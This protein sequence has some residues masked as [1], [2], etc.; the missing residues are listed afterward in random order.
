M[1]LKFSPLSPTV[2]LV[3]MVN[4]AKEYASGGSVQDEANIIIDSHREKI[5][6]PRFFE[7]MEIHARTR[8]I[9]LK[10]ERR[11][12]DRFLLVWGQPGEAIGKCVGDSEVHFNYS[13]LKNN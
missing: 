7:A 9:D 12:L 10:V 2:C 5:P 13:K 3:V 1:R 6:V 11:V 8:R 4:V